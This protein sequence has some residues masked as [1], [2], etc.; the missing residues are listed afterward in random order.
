MSQQIL[1]NRDSR[2][3]ISKNEMLIKE[4]QIREQA[5]L[6]KLK[7]LSDRINI[8]EN[9]QNQPSAKNVD[10]KEY[11]KSKA[12]DIG[13]FFAP[14][15][16]LTPNNMV[17]SNDSEN[18]Y[19]KYHKGMNFNKN[20]GYHIPE[21]GIVSEDDHKEITSS[22]YGMTW[23]PALMHYYPTTAFDTTA[24]SDAEGIGDT[25]MDM[26]GGLR[27]NDFCRL[28]NTS[29]DAKELTSMVQGLLEEE[30]DNVEGELDLIKDAQRKL[31]GYDLSF[32]G[33]TD[34][35]TAVAGVVE[36]V[37]TRKVQSG[38]NLTCRAKCVFKGKTKR[39]SCEAECDK[40]FKSSGKQENRRD[41]REERKTA[42]DEF[43]ADK[44]SCKAKLKSGEF[45]QW[46]YKECL[47]KERKEK[48]SDIK[49][50]G[51]NVATRIWR[52]T[53]VVNPLTALS[54][55]GV[56][57][58]VGDNTWG[59]ATRLAPA[60]LPDAQAKE[61][62]KPEAIEKA[63]KGWKKV[64]NGFRN[65]GGDDAKLKSK[66]IQG[67]KKKPYKVAKKSSFEGD[68]YE[69]EENSSFDG[70]ISAGATIITS[71]VAGLGALASLVSSFTKSGGEKNPYKDDKTPE[72]YKNALADGTIEGS[73]VADPKA[74][75]LNDKGEWTEPSTGKVIDPITG[76]YKDTI[77]G[78]NKWLAI[79]IGVAGVVGLYYIFKGKK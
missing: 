35:V 78:I 7:K 2:S 48:R 44:K 65:M 75:V 54:R 36:A 58:L 39:K 51:G 47:K 55:L 76:K 79:G 12:I 53:A 70:G 28:N 49:D 72:D 30:F 38:R 67:Y 57:V 60:L 10:L 5:C 50:A 69:F 20:V 37:D 1:R 34:G 23:N 62:F 15:G 45:Q 16:Y 73:P 13:K 11:L 14:M 56:L 32:E 71:V 4:M 46:Q 68:Y 64:A 29:E 40:K 59:F 63:K 74:P 19:L 31:Y 52:A 8:L 42:K 27:I 22:V 77:F 3:K 66:V 18:D 25:G 6:S 33:E 61:L 43:R 9:F 17:V 24:Y 21:R 41:E 26:I